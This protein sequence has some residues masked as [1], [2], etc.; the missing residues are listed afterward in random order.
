[1]HT[2]HVEYLFPC[3]MIFWITGSDIMMKNLNGLVLQ[4]CISLT[5]E[6]LALTLDVEQK[7]LYLMTFSNEDNTAWLGQLNYSS[8]Q[9]GERYSM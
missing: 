1:M 7:Y 5:T 3:R 4:T 9:C 8:E 2:L 6:P